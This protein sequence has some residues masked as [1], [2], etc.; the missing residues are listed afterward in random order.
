MSIEMRTIETPA[1]P[2]EIF[3]RTVL[4]PISGDEVNVFREVDRPFGDR[5]KGYAAGDVS[6]GAP[7]MDWPQTPTQRFEDRI[8]PMALA[9]KLHGWPPKQ[10]QTAT[11]DSEIERLT[12][13]GFDHLAA[14]VR[15][16]HPVAARIVDATAA[17]DVGEIQAAVN[18]HA[19]PGAWQRLA[20]L[21]G[22][23]SHGDH[24]QIGVSTGV[25]PTEDQA[26]FP[27]PFGDLV[28]N[29]VAIQTGSGLV[30]SRYPGFTQ[31]DQAREN[32]SRGY[33]ENGRTLNVPH[34]DRPKLADGDLPSR[35]DVIEIVT[36]LR[37]GHESRTAAFSVRH[38]N[39]GG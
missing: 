5:P 32:Q 31:A 29:A 16:R 35:E 2:R 18:L 22:R 24:G 36:L 23:H 10:A 14:I 27:E 8:E 25:K 1:G 9:N 34:A 30:T 7:P 38:R 33:D 15:E 19:V 21:I 28:S 3:R 26:F 17:F 37:P 20:E 39:S 11:V 12:A 13:S 6:K 4:C